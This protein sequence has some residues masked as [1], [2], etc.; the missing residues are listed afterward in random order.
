VLAACVRPHV[1]LGR[2]TRA[3]VQHSD[4]GLIGVQHLRAQHE[5]PVRVEQ[6][7]QAGAC[8]ARP[9]RQRG[10]RRVHAR[11]GINLLLPVVRQV[12][13]EAADQGVRQQARSRHALVDDL[14]LCGLLHQH[15]AALAG[16]LPMAVHEELGRHDGPP[17]QT[18][19]VLLR[20]DAPKLM[21]NLSILF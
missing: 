21:P 11:P 7:L 10:A 14:R 3:G 2:F 8:R 17:Q 15:L 12:V 18:G 1:S 19:A 6:R 5:G 16:H 4:R 20:R 13:H 9:G